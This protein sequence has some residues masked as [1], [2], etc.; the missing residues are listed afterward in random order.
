[1][2]LLFASHQHLEA[3]NFDHVAL[4]RGEAKIQTQ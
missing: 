2:S 4:A 3:S 1:M